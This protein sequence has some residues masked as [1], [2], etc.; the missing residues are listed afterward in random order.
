[1]VLESL[2]NPFTAEKRPWE[3]FFIGLL[4]NTIA[5]FLSLWIFYD[6]ASLVMVFLTVLACV[7]LIYSAIKME[8]EYDINNTKESLIL[9]E[10]A[11]VLYFLMFLFSGIMCSVVL[12]YVVLPNSIHQ[13]LFNIQTGT[14]ESINQQVTGN[15]VNTGILLKIFLNNMRVL[16]FCLLF[17]FFYGV[18]SIFILTWNASVIGVAIGNFIRTNISEYL[19]YFGVVP[20]AIFRY[21]THGFFEISAY[22]I[23]GLAGG[24]ISVAVIKH[25]F[26]TQNFERVLLDSVDL[27]LISV[28]LLVIAALIEVFITPVLF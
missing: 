17:S 10:H 4:Y 15:V 2:I 24:I 7:P 12:W 23:G 22:F 16:V 8:E 25:D 28:L 13:V 6:H 26:G 14:I 1:M 9:K 5:I 18:G 11:K 3:M 20:L 19:T 27:I 21:M